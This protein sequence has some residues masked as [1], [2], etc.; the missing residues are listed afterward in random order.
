MLVTAP[1]LAPWPACVPFVL[2]AGTRIVTISAILIGI[3]P[4]CRTRPVEPVAAIY[5]ALGALLK[6]PEVAS[7]V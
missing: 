5:T 2:P 4:A 7:P 1:I 3:G 6:T